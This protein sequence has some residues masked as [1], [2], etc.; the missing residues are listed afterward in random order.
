MMH[1]IGDVGSYDAWHWRH[2]PMYQEKGLYPPYNEILKQAV[3]IP[4]IT[5]G[6][7]DDP[8]LDSRAIAE[9]KTDMIGLARPLLADTDIP[10]KN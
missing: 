4:I 8:D 9:G 3:D 5:V 10:N 6:R 2:P 7:M 1:S